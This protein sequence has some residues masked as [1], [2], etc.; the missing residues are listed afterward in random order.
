MCLV[1]SQAINLIFMKGTGQNLIKKIFVLDYFSIDWKD[2][3]KIDKLNA[4][5][6]TKMY[7]SLNLG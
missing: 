4:D 6:L 2:L 1:R 5:N 7:L 3:K